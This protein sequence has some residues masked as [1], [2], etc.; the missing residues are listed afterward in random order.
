MH[1]DLSYFRRRA[2]QERTA[3]SAAVDANVRDA[4][5]QMAEHYQALI[6]SASSIEPKAEAAA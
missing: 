4:H 6:R 2:A 3:A 1:N 5:Q